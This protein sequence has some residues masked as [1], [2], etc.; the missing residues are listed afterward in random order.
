MAEQPKPW[1]NPK[2][3]TS[4]VSG[5]LLL[6]GWLISLAGAPEIVSTV[7]YLASLLTGGYYFG[8]EAI[9]ELI[10]ERRIGIETADDRRGSGGDGLGPGRGGRDA[11]VPLLHQR[12]G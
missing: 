4:V 1:R 12:G 9:E 11:G 8:R 10:F 6:V 7:L 5:L 3:I 2:V